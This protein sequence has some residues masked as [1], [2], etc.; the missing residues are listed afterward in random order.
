[1]AVL[2]RCYMVRTRTRCVMACGVAAIPA[3]DAASGCELQE[4]QRRRDQAAVAGASPRRLPAAV[5]HRVA[6][7]AMPEAGSGRGSRSR[8]GELGTGDR[9]VGAPAG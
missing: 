1:M 9:Q 7:Y 3:E 5:P 6:R 4:V 8:T 2:P